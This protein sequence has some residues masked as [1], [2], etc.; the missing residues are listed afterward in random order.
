M[1]I[2]FFG[3]YNNFFLGNLIW[4]YSFAVWMLQKI[5]VFYLMAFKNTPGGYTICGSNP[6]SDSSTMPGII[7]EI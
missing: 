2:V 4:N 5:I 1:E 6:L 3:K 7:L